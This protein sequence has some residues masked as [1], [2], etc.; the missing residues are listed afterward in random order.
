MGEGRREGGDQKV[1]NKCDLFQLPPKRINVFCLVKLVWHPVSEDG[2]GIAECP[3]SLTFFLL[4]FLPNPK[5]LS[6]HREE[7]RRE[8]GG[9]YWETSSCRHCVSAV[10]SSF[11]RPCSTSRAY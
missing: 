4:V 8:Q 1:E 6:L 11:S 9:L 10:C 3:C 2:C 5:M 7:E